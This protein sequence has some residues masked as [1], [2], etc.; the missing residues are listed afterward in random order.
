VINKISFVRNIYHKSNA[1]L[2]WI[3]QTAVWCIGKFVQGFIT[4]WATPSK[5]RISGYFRREN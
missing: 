5:L 4:V 2:H 1:S 3:L